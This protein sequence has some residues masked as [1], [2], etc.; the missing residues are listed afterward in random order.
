MIRLREIGEALGALVDPLR[1]VL[2]IGTPEEVETIANNIGDL[3]I[4]F[5]KILINSGVRALK[6]GE[7]KR[8]FDRNK[9]R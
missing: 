2:D 7:A 6:L 9:I 4:E 1:D 8:A 3:M 5:E